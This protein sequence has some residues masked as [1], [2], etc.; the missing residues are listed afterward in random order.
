MMLVETYVNTLI[1]V[2]YN[3]D[4]GSKTYGQP[5]E[6]KFDPTATKILNNKD[7]YISIFSYAQ[8]NYLV[9]FKNNK[10]IVIIFESVPAYNVNHPNRYNPSQGNILVVWE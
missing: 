1:R 3:W 9:W 8:K 6:I 7:T 2:E 4:W 10:D 5:K